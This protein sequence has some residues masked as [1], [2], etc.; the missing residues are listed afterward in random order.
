MSGVGVT[1][2]LN[3]WLALIEELL[4]RKLNNWEQQQ[5]RQMFDERES[6]SYAATVIHYSRPRYAA[7]KRE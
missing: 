1:K 3:G 6:A 7:A 5:A 2:S 4:G